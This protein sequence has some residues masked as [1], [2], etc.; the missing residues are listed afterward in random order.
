LN[1]QVRSTKKGGIQCSPPTQTTGKELSR[2][3]NRIKHAQTQAN[4]GQDAIISYFKHEFT[5]TDKLIKEEN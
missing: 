4:H 1:F 3:Q 2:T 5:E